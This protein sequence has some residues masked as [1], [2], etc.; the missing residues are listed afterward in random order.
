MANNV[1]MPVLEELLLII[2]N[3]VAAIVAGVNKMQYCLKAFM[4]GFSPK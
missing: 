4:S 1:P 2:Y 3:V